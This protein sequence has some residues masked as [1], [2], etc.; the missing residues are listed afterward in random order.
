MAYI[1]VVDDDPAVREVIRTFL[2]DTGH[3]IEEAGDGKEALMRLAG[4]TA[5]LVITDVY[6]DGMDGIEFLR[7]IRRTRPEARV[8]VMSGGGRLGGPLFLDVAE[9]LGAVRSLAKPFD[10]E[11]LVAEVA[12]ILAPERKKAPRRP[13]K[14]RCST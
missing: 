11:R 12:R 14:T 10:A 5:D 2:K 13:S 9:A 8:L 1:L 6:M 7:E 4:R 3:E